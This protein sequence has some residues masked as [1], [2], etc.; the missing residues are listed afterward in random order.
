M[1]HN[2]LFLVIDTDIFGKLERAQIFIISRQKMEM[3]CS[4]V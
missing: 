3:L 1:G 4:M 2:P